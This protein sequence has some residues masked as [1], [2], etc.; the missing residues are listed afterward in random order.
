MVWN[1]TEGF[2][3]PVELDAK[4]Y[5][6]AKDTKKIDDV[7]S[8]MSEV[9]KEFEKLNIPIAPKSTHEEVV[10]LFFTDIAKFVDGP[11]KKLAGSF[12][13]IGQRAD[14]LLK[15]DSGAI[16]KD[17]VCNAALNDISEAAWAYALATDR[18]TIEQQVTDYRSELEEKQRQMVEKRVGPILL[19]IQQLVKEGGNLATDAADALVRLKN[20]K[21][22]ETNRSTVGGNVEKLA[23]RMTTCIGNLQKLPE[24]VEVPGLQRADLTEMDK[25]HKAV[26]SYAQTGWIDNELDKTVIGLRTVIEQFQAFRKIG[27]KLN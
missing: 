18:E 14:N 6:K 20:G 8:S 21:D 15:K 1:V 19:A 5:K 25:I 22:I 23:R 4:T 12:K 27:L 26:L 11:G 10:Q 2:D 17:K 7:L 24:S 13:M 9:Q 16:K 3:W